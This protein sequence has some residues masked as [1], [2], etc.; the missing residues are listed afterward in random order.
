MR[1]VSLDVNEA[2]AILEALGCSAD[3]IFWKGKETTSQ[4]IDYYFDYSAAKASSIKIKFYNGLH[5]VKGS[6]YT[7]VVNRLTK[8]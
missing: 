1:I 8:R 2:L 7:M 3:P 4:D 5:L 6:L